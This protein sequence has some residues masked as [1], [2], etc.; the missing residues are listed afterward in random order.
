MATTNPAMKQIK[1][2]PT[3]TIGQTVGDLLEGASVDKA[4]MLKLV[5]LWRDQ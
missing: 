3:N 1:C 2:N 5:K 4:P